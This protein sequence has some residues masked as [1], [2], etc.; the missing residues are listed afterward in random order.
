MKL[1]INPLHPVFAAE[2]INIDL[3]NP[4]TQDLIGQIESAMNQYAVLVLRNQQIDDEQ[5][6][7]FA[8]AIGPLEPT[9]AV[10]EGHRR[11][12]KHDEMVDISNLEIDGSIIDTND[13]RRMFN[14]GNLLWHSDSSFNRR[15]PNTRCCMRARFRLKEA[16]RSSPT[17]ARHGMP[18]LRRPGN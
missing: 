2:V 6:L 3:R 17:C 9:P 12:L 1:D 13:R 4:A 10:V 11:R 5:Q 7:A 18:F 14:L 16:T 8:R 15:R